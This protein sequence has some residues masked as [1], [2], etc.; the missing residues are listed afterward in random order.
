M[1]YTDVMLDLE[2]MG[3]KSNSALVSIG[4]VEFNLITGETGREFYEVIDLQS[5]LD[6][7]LKVNASTIYWWLQQSQAA[8]DAICKDKKLHITTVLQRFSTWM[9]DCVA[10]VGI[11][12]NGARFDI[13]LLEDAHVAC[14]L[15]NPW[16]FRSEKDV[17][18]LVS[19]APQVKA[20]LPFTG[21]EHNPID[22]CKHQISYCT[23][24]W[25]KL[26]T[27]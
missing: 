23:A 13:G 11:W 16:Y 27:K 20:N 24:T 7:G 17:R 21:I 2:T 14:G 5:C 3:K 8:R 26:N 9:Q 19:F 4:A 25:K 10:E 18:T 22:D 6:V 1:E 12:G 15:K